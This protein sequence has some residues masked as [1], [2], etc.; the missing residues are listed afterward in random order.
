MPIDT[1]KIDKSFVDGIVDN[2][3]REN[4]LVKDIIQIAKHMDIVCLA[5]G[6]EKKEQVELLRNW[7][8]EYIQGFYYSKPVPMNEY[9]NLLTKSK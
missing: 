4:W 3:D 7:G 1:I 5:E 9:I 8:C 2:S 6:A